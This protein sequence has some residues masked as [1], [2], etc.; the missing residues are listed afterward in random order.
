MLTI[1]QLET[2]F[3]SFL[4]LIRESDFPIA[5]IEFPLTLSEDKRRKAG[6]E[7]RGKGRIRNASWG[8]SK[9]LVVHCLP[10]CELARW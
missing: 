9:R 4:P 8:Q 10:I 1:G 2:V 7:L 3:G 6:P 5:N